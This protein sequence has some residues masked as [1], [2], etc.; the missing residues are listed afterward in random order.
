MPFCSGVNPERRDLWSEK[1]KSS[2]ASGFDSVPLEGLHSPSLKVSGKWPDEL[3]GSF[4]RNGPAMHEEMG[5]RYHHWFDGDGM[6]HLFHIAKQEKAGGG[7][8]VSHTG[9]YVMTDKLHRE[10]DKGRRIYPAFGTWANGMLAMLTT[11]NAANTANINIIKYADRLM[12]LWEA[13][14]A[15]ELDEE[16]LETIAP[17]HW[18][19]L[20]KGLPF[21]AHPIVDDHGNM[22]NIGAAPWFSSLFCYQITPKRGLRQLACH[23]LPKMGMIH[24]F[25]HTANYLVVLLSPFEMKAKPKVS[26]LDSHRWQPREATRVV[27]IPKNNLNRIETIAELPA[28]WVFHYA[29]GYEDKKGEINI[30]AFWYEDTSIMT[31]TTADVMQGINKVG[32]TLP[33]LS[34]IRVNLQKRTAT[35]D[36]TDHLGEFPMTDPR[37]DNKKTTHTFSLTKGEGGGLSAVAKVSANQKTELFDYGAGVTCEEHLY[38]HHP[39]KKGAGWLMGTSR[40]HKDNKTSLSVLDAKNLAAG[41]IASVILPYGLP[42]GLHGSFVPAANP[43]SP[44]LLG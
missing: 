30:D 21:G 14:S 29:N 24:A 36:K 37:L 33:R 5:L 22:W 43:A 31:T 8:V 28:G 18:S 15:I 27:V 10:L 42:F 12:A 13:G 6:V 7:T 23:I 2:A 11:P 34:R 39:K 16:T 4:Y 1:Y 26:Y 25:C 32:A 40:N 3:H 35:I 9:R 20:S 41:P 38:I 17:I 19:R 44:T